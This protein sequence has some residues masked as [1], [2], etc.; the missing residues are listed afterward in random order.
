MSAS[1]SMHRTFNSDVWF[2]FCNCRPLPPIWPIDIHGKPTSPYFFSGTTQ[3]F[4]TQRPSIDSSNGALEYYCSLVPFC[5]PVRTLSPDNL[6]FS[7]T[8][9]VRIWSTCATFNSAISRSIPTCYT[10]FSRTLHAL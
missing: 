8:Q 7:R 5:S 1:L 6:D 3:P 10:P 2:R 4:T 9:Y